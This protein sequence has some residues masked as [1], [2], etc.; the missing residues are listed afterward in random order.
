MKVFSFFIEPSSYTLDLVNNVYRPMDIDHIFLENTSHAKADTDFD[1]DS[2]SQKSV[3]EQIGFLLSIYKNYDMIIFNGYNS[4]QF[5]FL[6]LLQLS[7]PRKKVIAIESDTR[8]L[9]RKG[10]KGL[11]KKL[12]L[13]PIFSYKYTLGFPGGNYTH[14]KLFSFYGMPEE[15][16]FLMPM[17]V[18]NEKYFNPAP[19][20]KEP[21]TFLFVG[22]MIPLKQIDFLI[23]SFLKKFEN[24]ENVQLKIVGGG[25]LFEPLTKAYDYHTNITFTGPK[26]GKELIHEYHTSN[27]LI[28]PSDREQWGLVINEAMAA[29]LPVIASDQVGAIYDLIIGKDTGFVFSLEKENDLAEKMQRLFEDREL[30]E[31][32]SAN[33]RRLMMEYWNYDLYKKNLGKAI[34]HAKELLEVSKDKR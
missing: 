7:L 13:S 5:I 29:G 12:Y 30:Y 24:D 14:K 8:F 21:F 11:I 34:E 23:Q 4:W 33:A 2:L 6:F 26:Y 1:A 20:A 9:K 15:N 10:L 18:D 31:R 28:L 16:I 22:R 27:V 19:Y 32:Y 25:E 17:M 3:I